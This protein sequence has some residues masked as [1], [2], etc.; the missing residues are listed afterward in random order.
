MT[1]RSPSRRTAHPRSRGENRFPWTPGRGC[2]GSSP[3]TRGKPALPVPLGDVTRLIPAHAGKTPI[4]TSEFTHYSAHPRSR[5]ENTAARQASRPRTGSSPLT[6][7]KRVT[8]RPQLRA[9]RLIPAHA[10]KT[11]CRSARGTGARA[12]P[13]SRGENKLK[14]VPELKFAGSS[15]LTRGK[16]EAARIVPSVVRLIPAHAGKT[17]PVCSSTPPPRAH[18]RSRGENE[19]RAAHNSEPTGS[20]PLTRG[21]P[22]GIAQI[23]QRRRLIPAH[24][25]KTR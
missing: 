3:L 17:S 16:P 5:G 19:S 6:R 15:P 8:G 24:A 1:G 20:S 9:D 11:G 7:G 10:G 21:K 23:A 13:R 25:G 14:F 4:R 22:Q 12:H 18:P 2:R